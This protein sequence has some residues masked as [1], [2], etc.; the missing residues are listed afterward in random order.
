[1]VSNRYIILKMGSTIV[2]RHIPKGC[3]QGGVLSPFLWNLVL[4]DLLKEFEGT[5]LLQAFADDICALIT[6]KDIKWTFDRAKMIV[7]RVNN[8]CESKGLKISEMK[9]QIILWRKDL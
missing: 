6:G 9:T 7:N 8:W 1:M 2:E 3:P 4:N 5:D